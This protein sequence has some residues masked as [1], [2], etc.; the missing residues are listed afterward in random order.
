MLRL[1]RI[2]KSRMAPQS[3][4]LARSLKDWTDELSGRV[5][6]ESLGMLPQAREDGE[7]VNFMTAREGEAAESHGAPS[8]E[9]ASLLSAQSSE[10]LNFLQGSEPLRNS[11]LEPQRQ[12]LAEM[13]RR[14]SHVYLFEG[15]VPV[16]LPYE[17]SDEAAAAKAAAEARQA[18][19]AAA[20]PPP[21][22][23]RGCLLP[24]LLALLALLAL[25]FALWWFL[26][27]P[28][29]MQ[30]TFGDALSRLGL[31][32]LFKQD[33]T[34]QLAE[35]D[36]IQKRAEDLLKKQDEADEAARIAA[37]KKRQ[38][39]LDALKAQ[40]AKNED[41]IK[42]LQKRLEEAEKA[43]AEAAKAA[44]A[45]KPEPVKQE[46]KKVPAKPEKKVPE[47]AVPAKASTSARALP[48]CRVLKKEG[49]MPKMVIAF[50][51]S[52]S[53]LIPDVR[54]AANRLDAATSAASSLVNSIDSNVQIGFV[55]INGCPSAKSRGFFSGTQ[56]QALR[57]TIRG[58][59][60]M[61]YDGMTPLVNGLVQI[62]NMTDGV[63]ADAVGVLISDGED[64]CPVTKNMNVCSVARSIHARKPRLKI[65]TVLIGSDAGQAACIAR[66]TGGRVYS[67]R[68]AAQINAGLQ[69]TGA[70]MRK[71][72]DNN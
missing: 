71:V 24:F 54:G 33:Y 9:A 31:D 55:E 13:I 53:M 26:L 65:H 36:E 6:R 58:V 10:L 12:Y 43:R 46:P 30:G 18:K 44:K 52:R 68:D 7:C 57:Q 45:V 40:G 41:E 14:A 69:A 72:C 50:D 63:N 8:G 17:T 28:W 29:P 2:P 42:E 38:E 35:L 15:R 16:L 62:A 21:P 3:L 34:S 60:P 67:P 1:A 64:T 4:S 27:R 5:S 20:V 25:L 56:R 66:I 49:K 32:S 37:E 70:E 61:R 11:A 22:K 47:K 23:K 39:E 48:K 59:N 19:A 51:G